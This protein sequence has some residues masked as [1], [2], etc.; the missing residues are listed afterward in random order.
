MS[1]NQNN[2]PE[3]PNILSIQSSVVF[4]V[5]GNKS[6]VFPLQLFGYNVSPINTVQFSNHTGYKHFRGSKT[7]S[8]EM[9][10]LVL[11]LKENNLFSFKY[12][13]TGYMGSA[14]CLHSLSNILKEL[15]QVNKKLIIIYS[16]L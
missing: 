2:L 8:K 13:I 14:D 1:S 16:Y 7:S 5:A 3:I 6:A 12:I 15:S 9:E 11:G 4:G 10:E